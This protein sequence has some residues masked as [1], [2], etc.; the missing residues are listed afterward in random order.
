MKPSRTRQY[1]IFALVL[2]LSLLSTG[3]AQTP[4]ISKVE[5]PNWWVGLP[6][7][8]L[9][10][11]TGENLNGAQIAT[12]YPGVTVQRLNT[13]ADGHYLFA[14]IHLAKTA[15]AGRAE[16][17]VR[18]AK[19]SAR[20]SAGDSVKVAWPLEKRSK[21]AETGNGLHT[22]DIL[23][24]IMPDR[25]ANGDPTNDDPPGAT[26]K[27]DR[28]AA[29][30]YHGGDLKGVEQHLDYLRELG[31]TAVWL[32]P[33]WKNSSNASDYHGYHVTDFY[34]VDE[35]FGTLGELQHFVASA[36]ARGIKVVSDYVANHIGP[37][38][39]WADDPP[40][41]TWLH[42]TRANHLEPKYDFWPLVDI[43]ST[44]RDRRPVIEGWFAGKLP[45]LNPD[46]P[47]LEEYLADNAIWW[48]ESAHFDAYRLDT[49]PYSS[50]ES[51]SK[52]HRT[53]REVYPRVTSV[54]ECF[55]VSPVVTSYFE[56]GHK[57]RGVDSGATTVF[58]FPVYSA[59][60]AVLAH[61]EPV[62]KLVN[63]FQHDYLYQHPEGLYTFF[64]NHDQPRLMSEKG[65]TV[66]KL[67]AAFSLL[68]TLRGIPGIYYGDEI[69]MTGGEDPE[70]R[71]D[72]PGG[73]VGDAHNAF[74][75]AGRTPSEQE[76]FA[77]VQQLNRLHR[78]HRALQTGEMTTLAYSDTSFSYLRSQGEDRLLVIFNAAEKAQ[79]IEVSRADTP[80]A[81][82][83]S[84]AP[85]LEAGPII[86][87]PAKLTV[88]AAPMSVAIYSLK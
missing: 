61:N 73:W 4:V 39:R 33:W 44:E 60:R 53:L 7:D 84:A 20:D 88:E 58:D 2:L 3:W 21:V 72:F 15:A 74:T 19:G 29:K 55:D 41:A 13:S 76:V 11:L 67:K 40:T 46:D 36:H 8:P 63:V 24:L 71:H 79:T 18:S 6:H 23:Y 78:Q 5:P 66:A 32:T 77:H 9:L 64:G 50:R 16:F 54:A 85:L 68:L 49:F 14:R 65:A 31:V 81:G 70:N 57:V 17:V 82:I 47:L 34:A 25:F 43:H 38:H 59:L 30:G 83:A 35:H 27:H 48:M 26:V 69:A 75:Q 37:D 22:D 80:L 62:G 86:V 87:T 12:H 51:W 56:G 28:T 1:A 45:D 52:W 42:G 10:L